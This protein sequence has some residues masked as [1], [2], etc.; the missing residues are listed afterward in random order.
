MN[1]T[2]ILGNEVEE[3]PDIGAVVDDDDDDEVNI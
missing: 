3:S 2:V 1:I